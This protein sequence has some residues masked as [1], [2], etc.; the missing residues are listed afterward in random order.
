M[1]DNLAFFCWVEIAFLARYSN[2]QSVTAT[3]IVKQ[4]VWWSFFLGVHENGREREKTANLSQLYIYQVLDL[5]SL[6]NIIFIIKG[7]TNLGMKT[8][9]YYQLFSLYPHSDLWSEIVQTHT[10]QKNCTD[11][12]SKLRTEMFPIQNTQLNFILIQS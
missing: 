2:I 11:L 4:R 3:Y 1:L 10:Q 12:Q 8:E 9:C 7:E 5:Y 6:V